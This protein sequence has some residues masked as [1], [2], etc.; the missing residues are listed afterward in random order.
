[1]EDNLNIKFLAWGQDVSMIYRMKKDSK[2]SRVK[3]D[4]SKRVGISMENL[5]F[6]INQRRISALVI[7]E[8][9]IGDDETPKILGMKTNDTVHVTFVDEDYHLMEF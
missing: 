9:F 6:S 8:W 1:M 7:P 2:M 5:K 3:K 4:Y